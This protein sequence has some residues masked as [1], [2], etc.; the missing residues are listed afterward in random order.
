MSLTRAN[1]SEHSRMVMSSR[2]YLGGNHH[3]PMRTPTHPSASQN[4]HLNFTTRTHANRQHLLLNT[5][6]LPRIEHG[7]GDLA[8]IK[9]VSIRNPQG[10]LTHKPDP[11]GQ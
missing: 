9:L 1:G 7:T 2:T 6:H 4:H 10:V 8:P 5:Q 11:S 3:Q